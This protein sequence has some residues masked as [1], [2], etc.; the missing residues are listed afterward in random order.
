[1][2]TDILRGIS[3]QTQKNRWFY[4]TLFA[5]FAVIAQQVS[6]MTA[7]SVPQMIAVGM[8]LGVYGSLLIAIIGLDAA[9]QLR[10]ALEDK[11]SLFNAL[12]GFNIA[13]TLSYQLLMGELRLLAIAGGIV[14]WL[15]PALLL[16]QAQKNKQHCGIYD[17]LLLLSL[18]VP[19][20]TGVIAHVYRVPEGPA[21]LALVMAIPAATV[22]L[23]IA[24]VS[25][26]QFEDVGLSLKHCL[27][28][29]P[30]RTAAQY[31]AVALIA[32]AAYNAALGR[33]IMNPQLADATLPSALMQVRGA[34]ALLLFVSLPSELLFRGLILNILEKT[35]GST[36]LAVACAALISAV[37]GAGLSPAP[38]QV[39]AGLIAGVFYG[40]IYLKTASVLPGAVA[41]ALI[42]SFVPNLPLG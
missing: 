14:Y 23:A 13:L 22:T 37:A 39:G 33:P 26:R 9:V 5:W 21:L 29:S 18:W 11:P 8:T 40:L 16:R 3:V 17:I 27:G 35:S 1:M 38:E 6:A 19:I 12:V 36:W 2:A 4:F 41:G 7:L 20:H 42:A 31:L 28:L 15:V 10:P 34:A 24:T 30:W 32:L 25:V